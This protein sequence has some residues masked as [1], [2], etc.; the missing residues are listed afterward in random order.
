MGVSHNASWFLIHGA[1]NV[2]DADGG[3]LKLQG[4]SV[5]VRI[6]I[7]PRPWGDLHMQYCVYRGIR[8]QPK[9]GVKWT[10]GN[11]QVPVI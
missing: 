11:H 3:R 8:V 10:G 4:Q 6:Q 7:R 2:I 9:T 1:V 5:G